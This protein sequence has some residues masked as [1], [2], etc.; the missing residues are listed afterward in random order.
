MSMAWRGSRAPG[1]A[2]IGLT[3]ALPVLL[4]LLLSTCMGLLSP[5]S[6]QAQADPVILDTL[7]V[8][9]GS[10]L[11]SRLPATTRT[12]QVLDLKTIESLPVRTIAGLLEWA[13]SIEVQPRSP[14]QSDLSIRGAGFEQVVVLVNGVRMSDLQTGHFDL[15]LSV[16]LGQVERIEILRGPAS[17]L[18]GADAMG[19]VVNIV[20]RGHDPG[21]RGRI[22]GGS[23][24][25]ARVSGGG[26]FQEEGWPAL[27]IGGELSRSDG[28]RAGTDFD[29]AMIH[30]SVLD[31]LAGTPLAGD[32]GFS[33]RNFGAKDFYAPYPS[34]EKTRTYSSA[35]RWTPALS[36]EAGFEVGASLRRREDE[37]TLI[38]DDPG[39]YQNRHTSSQAGG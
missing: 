27:Q 30:L 1:G 14:A 38:R 21:W 39:V 36:P 10:R 23:W 29:A 31:S 20:T 33:R 4:P 15:D 35:L 3:R 25:T 37:F 19:G 32:F 12:V 7:V 18:Y 2:E 13:T 34:F 5:R 9:V 24:G 26:G 22:E 11:D 16:P 28:H 8:Q 6:V 17:A